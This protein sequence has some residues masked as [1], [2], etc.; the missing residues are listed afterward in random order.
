MVPRLVYNSSTVDSPMTTL[1]HMEI[2]RKPT[3]DTC[4]MLG[5][6]SDM[7]RSMCAAEYSR[8]SLYHLLLQKFLQR[9]SDREPEVLRYETLH[10]T[11]SNEPQE[12]LKVNEIEKEHQLLGGHWKKL[13]EKRD[14]WGMLLDSCETAWESCHATDGVLCSLEEVH[15]HW[16]PPAENQDIL[17][18]LKEIEVRTD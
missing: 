4:R 18:Q 1:C 10:L 7:Y 11:V 14:S 15:A 3:Q 2:H 13:E 9:V 17:A 16:E 6:T 5:I 12:V 8:H